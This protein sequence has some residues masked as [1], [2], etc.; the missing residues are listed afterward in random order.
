MARWVARTAEAVSSLSRSPVFHAAPR[1]Q[2][3]MQHPE[4][5]RDEVANDPTHRAW[6]SRHL[7]MVDLRPRSQPGSGSSSRGRNEGGSASAVH[8]RGALMLQVDCASRRR[9][10]VRGAAE[11]TAVSPVADLA[12]FFG[13]GV[14]DMQPSLAPRLRLFVE[15]TASRALYESVAPNR[16]TSSGTIACYGLDLGS[17]RVAL[18]PA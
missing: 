2:V 9:R 14:D 8:V 13:R 15:A 16:T 3:A 4:Q 11:G 12:T 17:E 6:C 10:A 18:E 1:D 5:A 7:R